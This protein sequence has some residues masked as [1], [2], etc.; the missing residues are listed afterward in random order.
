MIINGLITHSY[1]P[2]VRP[3][4]VLVFLILEWLGQGGELQIKSNSL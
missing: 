2:L 1:R 3:S 4:T